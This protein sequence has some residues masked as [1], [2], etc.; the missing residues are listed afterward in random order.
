[1][2]DYVGDLEESLEVLRDCNVRPKTTNIYGLVQPAMLPPVQLCIFKDICRIVYKLHHK[3]L[4]LVERK[5]WHKSD[6]ASVSAD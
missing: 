4:R 2:P 1:M 6:G 5:V 3:P